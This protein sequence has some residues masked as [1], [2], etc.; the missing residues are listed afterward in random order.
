MYEVL[1]KITIKFET[2]HQFSVVKKLMCLEKEPVGGCSVHSLQAD[3]GFI[4]AFQ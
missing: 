2:L 1:D 3:G 4:V